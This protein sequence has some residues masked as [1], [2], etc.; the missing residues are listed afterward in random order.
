MDIGSNINNF[1]GVMLC[2]RPNDPTK[3]S[4]DK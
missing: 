2:S 1:K 3:P 4:L